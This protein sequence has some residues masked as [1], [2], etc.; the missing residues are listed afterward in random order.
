MK[1]GM[2]SRIYSDASYLTGPGKLLRELRFLRT[3]GY[4]Y[5]VTPE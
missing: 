4:W 2:S 5:E 1:Q 3:D